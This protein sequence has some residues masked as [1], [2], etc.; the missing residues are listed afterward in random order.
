MTGV[1]ADVSRKQRADVLKGNFLKNAV[2]LFPLKG[3][4]RGSH[5]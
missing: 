1:P 5:G 4:R 2:A 3:G